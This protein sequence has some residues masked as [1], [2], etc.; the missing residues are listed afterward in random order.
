MNKV[1]WF[2]VVCV[3]TR[4]SNIVYYVEIMC[5]LHVA[6]PKVVSGRCLEKRCSVVC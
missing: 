2:N 3:T 1:V 5:D 4:F 6:K